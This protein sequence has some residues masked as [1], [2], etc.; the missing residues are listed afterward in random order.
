MSWHKTLQIS[1]FIT[2]KVYCF[3]CCLC[4]CVSILPVWQQMDDD[5]CCMSTRCIPFYCRCPLPMLKY[6]NSDIYSMKTTNSWLI[7]LIA[8]LET[9]HRMGFGSETFVVQ[10]SH[11]VRMQFS[12][13]LQWL[14]FCSIHVFL[15]L[16][17][18]VVNKLLLKTHSW[19]WIPYTPIR[20]I[21]HEG[22]MYLL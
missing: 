6:L 8:S 22:I 5:V 10:S 17:Q 12:S 20:F 19:F 13:Y 21:T 15:N 18:N 3:V 9:F 7:R 11:V 4:C 1:I 16:K 14:S 2:F